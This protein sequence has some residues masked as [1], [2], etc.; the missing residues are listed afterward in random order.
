MHYQNSPGHVL[1]QNTGYS[2]SRSVLGVFRVTALKSWIS[3]IIGIILVCG[4]GLAIV[5]AMIDITLQVIT[6]GPALTGYV[7]FLPV[8]IAM[9]LLI[10]GFPLL[11]S[12]FLN[13]KKSIVV[14][15]KGLSYTD[16]NGV[17][18]W[19][20]GNIEWF[21]I[22]ITRYYHFGIHTRTRYQY[23]LKSLSGSEL[24]LDDRLVNIETLGQIIAQKVTP[25]QF[26]KI[27]H[28]TRAGQTVKLGP[29]SIDKN[30]LGVDQ[31]TYTWDDIDSV[32]IKNGYFKVRKRGDG[33]FISP[34][35]P[36]SAIPNLDA[37]VRIIS[38]I[39]TVEIT[40]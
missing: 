34:K 24:K 37:L 39:V 30:G 6:H 31:R 29:I 16:H 5:Y 33:L 14:F 18:D 23:I 13:W 20:W 28:A 21:F 35:T 11:L 32:E 1:D 8:V 26:R 19:D 7:I 38:Q 22:T 4:A 15:D 40:Q 10:S 27:L 36:I 9:L 3:A 25:I 2:D 12:G 17:R